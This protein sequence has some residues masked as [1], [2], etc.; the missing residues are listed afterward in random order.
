[1]ATIAGSVKV[2]QVEFFMQ[3]MKMVILEFYK[4][5][6][7]SDENDTVY[8]DNGKFF[9]IKNRNSSFW[10]WCYCFKWRSKQLIDSS[11]IE[12]AFGTEES[13]FY[14]RRFRFKSWWI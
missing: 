10:K 3:K 9:I 6:I 2:Y 14:K 13:C 12:T 1:M 11:L 7:Q 5:V 8:G 4:K